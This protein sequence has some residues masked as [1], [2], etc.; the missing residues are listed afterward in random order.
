MKSSLKRIPAEELTAFTGWDPAVFDSKT[1]SA[2]DARIEDILE[3]FNGF[4]PGLENRH[5]MG[6]PSF[7]QADMGI[8]ADRWKP[9]EFSWVPPFNADPWTHLDELALH[10][11]T[12]ALAQEPAVH[13]PTPEEIMAEIL[14]TAR[15]QADEMLLEAQKNADEMIAQAQEEIS[16]SVTKGYQ[17]GWASSQAEATTVLQAAHQVVAE[18]IQWR[19]EMLDNSESSVISILRDIAKFMFGDGVKLDEMGLQVNLN[20][21]LENAKSLGNVRIFLNPS[22]AIHLDPGWREY[23]SMLS[24]NKVM[25]VPSEGIKPGGCFIQGETGSIDA[26]VEAQLTNA[27]G[28]FDQRFEAE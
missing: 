25:I 23:Q 21:V 11:G 13:Q 4:L 14:T 19:S 17:Q 8:A 20:R 7:I 12:P 24:G 28:V 18:L 2:K 16:Q 26:R 6:N 1:P 22:D 9:D 3:I 10:Q 27:L 5:I 15:A